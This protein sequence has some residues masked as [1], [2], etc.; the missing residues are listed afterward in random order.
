MK[1]YIAC[2]TDTSNEPATFHAFATKEQ[3][4]NFVNKQNLERNGNPSK[5]YYHVAEGELHNENSN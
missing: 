5:P 1:I 3:A 2:G 4:E